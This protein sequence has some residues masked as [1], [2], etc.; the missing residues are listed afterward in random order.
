MDFCKIIGNIKFIQALYLKKLSDI[1]TLKVDIFWVTSC[2]FGV[3]TRI[4]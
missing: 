1:S 2:V 4:V 3:Y